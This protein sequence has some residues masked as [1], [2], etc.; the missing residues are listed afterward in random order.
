MHFAPTCSQNE[1]EGFLLSHL[2][3]RALHTWHAV[4]ARLRGYAA[5]PRGA[6]RRGGAGLEPEPWT[7]WGF[8]AGDSRD[9]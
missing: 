5:V 7:G 3:L 2:V 8:A 1:Q 4:F 9:S 6:G